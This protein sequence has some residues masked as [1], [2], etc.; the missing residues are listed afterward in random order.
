MP[1]HVKVAFI[2]LHSHFL[3][4][5]CNVEKCFFLSLPLYARCKFKLCLLTGKQHFCC[6]ITRLL[7]L[8]TSIP[9]IYF[10]IHFPGCS[11]FRVASILGPRISLQISQLV[12]FVTISTFQFQRFLKL[13]SQN[14]KTFE[15]DVIQ[16]GAG[17]FS[18]K[19]VRVEG[20]RA[21]FCVRSLTLDD[22]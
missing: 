3:S 14:N 19:K 9:L 2:S 22:P 12:L 18:V 6:L 17:N 20:V 1:L 21:L 15:M 16:S 4:T 8:V 5:T 7:L 11:F 10:R 13:R